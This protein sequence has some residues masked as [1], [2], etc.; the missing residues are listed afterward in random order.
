MKSSIWR[1][2]S[3]LR[4]PP[5]FSAFLLENHEGGKRFAFK[6]FSGAVLFTESVESFERDF[7]VDYVVRAGGGPHVRARVSVLRPGL[8][9]LWDAY[10]W[11]PGEDAADAVRLLVASSVMDS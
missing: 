10:V 8:P 1:R 11:V 7:L 2:R 3:S 6:S 4:T 5:G 9:G